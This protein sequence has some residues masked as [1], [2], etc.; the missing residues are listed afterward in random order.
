MCSAGCLWSVTYPGGSAP[1]V[2]TG[3]VGGGTLLSCD[4]YICF[5]GIRG[6]E[7]FQACCCSLSDWARLLPYRGDGAKHPGSTLAL[8]APPAVTGA[9]RQTGQ[10]FVPAQARLALPHRRSATRGVAVAG[11]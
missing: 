9:P 11:R 10:P 8:V 4:L 6:H 1:Q 2:N 5:Q 3:V 7:A